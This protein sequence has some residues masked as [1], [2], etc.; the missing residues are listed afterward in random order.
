MGHVQTDKRLLHEFLENENKKSYLYLM[1]H[2]PEQ[3]A[4]SLFKE[5]CQRRNGLYLHVA[6]LQL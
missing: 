2:A 3:L 4:S 1:I 6:R 5:I